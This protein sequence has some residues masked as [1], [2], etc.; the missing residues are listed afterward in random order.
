MRRNFLRHIFEARHMDRT[1]R[2]WPRCCQVPPPRFWPDGF[3]IWADSGQ[4]LGRLPRYHTF[5]N[6]QIW[7]SS[8]KESG[9]ILGRIWPDSQKNSR[10]WPDSGADSGQIPSSDHFLQISTKNQFPAPVGIWADSGG[11]FWADSGSESGQIPLQESGQ[12]LG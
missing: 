4:I 5:T 8:W 7:S 3:S 10:I 2:I 6:E 9:Q 12:I 1:G 11:R